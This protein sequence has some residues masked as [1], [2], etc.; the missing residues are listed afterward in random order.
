MTRRDIKR[1][2]ATL[3]EELGCL[4]QAMRAGLEVAFR[5]AE[6]LTRFPFGVRSDVMTPNV[7]DFF[8]PTPWLLLSVLADY[9]GEGMERASI[10]KKRH[11]RP[12]P[13]ICYH[14]TPLSN[15]ARIESRGLA[16]GYKVGKS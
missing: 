5:D 4:H 2:M 10:L 6:D 16:P 11:W 13:A 15:R 14:A 7:Y 8:R 3:P 12:N 9:L 1:L